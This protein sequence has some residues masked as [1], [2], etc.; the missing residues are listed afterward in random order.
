MDRFLPTYTKLNTY[1]TEVILTF[2]SA[3]TVSKIPYPHFKSIRFAYLIDLRNH[4]SFREITDNSIDS[5][6]SERS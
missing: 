6:N 4:Q 2:L 5:G 3:T 1:F